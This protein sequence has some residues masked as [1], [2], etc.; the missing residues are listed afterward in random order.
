MILQFR[1]RCRAVL[2]LLLCLVG[3][4]LAPGRAAAQG[5]VPTPPSDTTET[6][7]ISARGALLRSFAVPG[8]GQIYAQAPGRGAVY[9]GMEAASVWML[10]K[11]RTQLSSSRARDRWL[12][13]S[14]AL[15]EGQISSLTRARSRQF[16]DWATMSVFLALFSGADAYVTAQLSDFAEQVQVRPGEGGALQIRAAIPVGPGR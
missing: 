15:A 1:S 5:R 3:P 11:S 9:F 2:L 6:N 12:R 14:N 13:E 16:E 8:W 7:G 4:S 10:V